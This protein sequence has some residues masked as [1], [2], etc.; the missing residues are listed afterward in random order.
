MFL[1]CL[2]LF[3]E[4]RRHDATMLADS[5]LLQ[6]MQ[7]NAFSPGPAGRPLCVH[8]NPAYTLRVYLQTPFRKMILTP[9][10]VN[11]NKAM[12]SVRVSVEW[13]FGD[14]TEYFKLCVYVRNLRLWPQFDP[15]GI[16]R[17]ISVFKPCRLS[18]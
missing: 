8:G 9:Q 14:I 5:N 7:H 15:L 17:H 3:K 12:S 18:R 10:M 6:D 11:F 1:I 16:L 4:G 13:L 2:F